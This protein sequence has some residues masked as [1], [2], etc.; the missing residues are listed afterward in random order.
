MEKMLVLKVSLLG[1]LVKTYEFTKD[2]VIVGRGS[3]ADVQLDHPAI[4]RAHLRIERMENG[5]VFTDIGSSNGTFLN[6]LQCRSGIL[7]PGDVLQLGKYVLHVDV[8]DVQPVEELE[9]SLHS[10]V[11]IR[12]HGQRH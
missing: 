2:K 11:T 4:S 1:H 6:H 12:M 3:R 9:D 8:T 5:T 10:C 7:H